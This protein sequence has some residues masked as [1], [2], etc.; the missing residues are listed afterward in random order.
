M[1][2]LGLRPTDAAA[3]VVFRNSI[4]EWMRRRGFSGGR[5]TCAEAIALEFRRRAAYR[6]P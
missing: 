6:S 2:E 4:A 3:Q 5:R 1:A